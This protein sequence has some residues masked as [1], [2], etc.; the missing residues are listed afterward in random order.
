MSHAIK[1]FEVSASVSG[2]KNEF[3]LIRYRVTSG[4]PWKSLKIPRGLMLPFMEQLNRE[5]EH[6]DRYAEAFL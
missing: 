4:G 1:T 2:G 5:W 6:T 3:L